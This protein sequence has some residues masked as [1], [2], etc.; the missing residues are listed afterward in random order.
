MRTNIFWIAVT[1]FAINACGGTSPVA[2][3]RP[4]VTQQGGSVYT[5]S[6]APAPPAPPPSSNAL[7]GSYAM[8]LEIGRSCELPEEDR[9]RHYSASIAEREPGSLIVTLGSATFLDGPI[10]TA[11]PNRAAGVGCNQFFASSND[12]TAQFVL[13]NNNDD[14]HGGHIVERLSSGTWLEIIG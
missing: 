5:P 10:C 14:A 1:T 9:V 12:G 4:A 13:E 7:V 2:P 6:P 8:T 11:G 3:A